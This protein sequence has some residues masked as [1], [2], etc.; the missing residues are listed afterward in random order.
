MTEIKNIFTVKYFVYRKYIIIAVRLER[1]KQTTSFFFLC[2]IKTPHQ[3]IWYYF[4]LNLK[5][6][7]KLCTKFLEDQTNNVSSVTYKIT[8]MDQL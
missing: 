3:V 4:S 6:K 8:H 5:H 7:G 1:V 2:N